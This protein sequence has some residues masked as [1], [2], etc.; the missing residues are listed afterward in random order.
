MA[1][2]TVGQIASLGAMI[3]QA[4]SVGLSIYS[5]IEAFIKIWRHDLTPEQMHDAIVAV[6]AS[7]EQHRQDRERMIS[8][9][10]G[11]SAVGA[12]DGGSLGDLIGGGGSGAAGGGTPGAATATGGNGSQTTGNAPGS[13]GPES[14]AAS[15]AGDGGRLPD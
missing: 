4:E 12:F 2:F 11:G 7:A 6:Q 14:S 3:V 10:V 1:A 15:D 9:G 8:G 5:G 13:A